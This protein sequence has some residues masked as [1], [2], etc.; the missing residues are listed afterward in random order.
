[1]KQIK[2]I[3]NYNNLDFNSKPLF[4]AKKIKGFIW[5]KINK[6]SCFHLIIRKNKTKILEEKK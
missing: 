5:L 6:Y 1:M 4:V 2:K 3:E